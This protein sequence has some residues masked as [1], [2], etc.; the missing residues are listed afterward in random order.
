MV[1]LL[2]FWG[3]QEKYLYRASDYKRIFV[4]IAFNIIIMIDLTTRMVFFEKVQVMKLLTVQSAPFPHYLVCLKPR[5]L[6]QL[7]IKSTASALPS[8]WET[9][10]YT[11]IKQK[12]KYISVY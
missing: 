2:Q 4:P 12:E 7:H 5:C 3:G 10:F 1:L 9:K 11:H 8:V 6:P